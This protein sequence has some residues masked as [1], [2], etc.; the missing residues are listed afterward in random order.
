MARIRPAT[1]P[2][3]ATLE[4]ITVSIRDLTGKQVLTIEKTAGVPITE[5]ANR[6][7]DV[8]LAIGVRMAVEG[9]ERDDYL[10]FPAF[11]IVESVTVDLGDNEDD[12][13]G[14][15]SEKPSPSPPPSRSSPSRPSDSA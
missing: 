9:G 13:S 5:L 8:L 10:A 2:K 7:S 3:L 15:A 4:P 12:D 14:E 6:S 1:A 11:A